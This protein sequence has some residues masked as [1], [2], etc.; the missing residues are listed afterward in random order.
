M[1]SFR[2]ARQFSSLLL[3]SCNLF[4]LLNLDLIR[5]QLQPRPVNHLVREDSPQE[6][7][8]ERAHEGFIP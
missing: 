3:Q 6:H 5:L 2:R 4:V 1:Q 7:L 8:G